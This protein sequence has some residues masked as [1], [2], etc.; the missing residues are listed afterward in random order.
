MQSVSTAIGGAVAA[1]RSG[2]GI[3]AHARAVQSIVLLASRVAA[4]I[5]Y[6]LN[7]ERHAGA[8]ARRE[9]LPAKRDMPRAHAERSGDRLRRDRW[10]ISPTHVA[11]RHLAVHRHL[12]FP[13][14]SFDFESVPYERQAKRRCYRCKRRGDFARA[15]L[16]EGVVGERPIAIPWQYPAREH[17]FS[18]TMIPRSNSPL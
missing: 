2:G 12:L 16:A 13:L 15:Q 14:K 18:P 7:I 6:A 1:A 10:R 9:A 11:I 3:P 5:A 17:V 4:P 8:A